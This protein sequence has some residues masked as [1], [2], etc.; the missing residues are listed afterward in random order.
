M[1]LSLPLKI[2][3]KT[4]IFNFRNNAFS[5]HT[6]TLFTYMHLAVSD[7]SSATSFMVAFCVS[8]SVFFSLCSSCRCCFVDLSVNLFFVS[9][10]FTLSVKI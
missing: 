7:D 9:S 6:P 8:N 3:C 1:L 10:F 4:G 2:I 5:L